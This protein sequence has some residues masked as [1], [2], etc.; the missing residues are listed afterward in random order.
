MARP[1]YQPPGERRLAFGSARRRRLRNS[2]GLVCGPENHSISST[3]VSITN[4]RKPG[5]CICRWVVEALGDMIV[6]QR[7]ARL[8]S[9]Q[10]REGPMDVKP[11]RRTRSAECSSRYE[12]KA[13]TPINVIAEMGVPSPTIAAASG[14]SRS[15]W[16]ARIPPVTMG[17]IAH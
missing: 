1:V 15:F 11:T 4:R 8:E 6:E 12:T 16:V 14:G 10:S 5:V 17:P 2:S 7:R 3:I 9:K 13:S